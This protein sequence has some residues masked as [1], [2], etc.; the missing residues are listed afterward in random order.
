MRK[1]FI[2]FLTLLINYTIAQNKQ[3]LYNFAGLPQSALLNPAI[4]GDYKFHIGIPLLS[5]LSPEISSTRFTLTDVFAED[6]RNINDKISLLLDNLDS[7]DFLKVN[8]QVEILNAGFRINNTLYLSFGFYEEID[9]I[10]Y[11]PKDLF[12]LFVEGN[13]SNINKSF[14]ASQVNYKLDILGVLHFGMSKEIDQ[15]LRLGARFKIYSSALNMQSTNNTGTLNTVRGTNNLYTHYFNNINLISR[16]SG[17]VNE[18]TNEYIEDVGEYL[19]NTFFGPNMGVGFDFGIT[20]KIST[21]LEFSASILD[22][23]FV[24][25]KKNVKNTK[26]EGNFSYE[27]VDFLFDAENSNFWDEINERFKRDLPTTEN[28]EGY[29]SWRPTKINV[30]LKYSFGERRS[31]ICYDN[32]YKDFYTDAIGVQLFN[33]F[34]PLGNQLALTTF[35]EK[36]ITKKIHT[37]FT[38]TIDDFSYSNVGAGFSAQFGNFNMY[39]TLDNI[40]SYRNLFS[41][42]HLSLQLGFNL[43]F[44]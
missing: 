3:V 15:D 19:G 40:L 21:Q 30:A 25:H 1:V 24:S 7:N 29:I 42:N 34:R 23:G 41:T 38:Y 16:T 6:G 10:G 36:S 33:V 12:T 26:V 20:H 4:D 31:R 17:L 43:I 28:Q 35:Y 8:T 37:K 13:Y 14:M 11:I 2:L 22:F 5:G 27:G 39:A 32:R 44:N 9:A 18:D